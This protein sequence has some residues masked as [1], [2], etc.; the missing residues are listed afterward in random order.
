MEFHVDIEFLFH[1]FHFGIYVKMHVGIDGGNIG[2][3]LSHFLLGCGG[4]I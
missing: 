2:I 4:I 1:F 3:D